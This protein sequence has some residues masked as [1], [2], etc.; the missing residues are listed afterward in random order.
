MSET[1]VTLYGG[2]VT[3]T[4]DD[5]AHTYLWE[6][7]G[8]FLPGPTTAIGTLPKP[9]LAPWAAKEMYLELC[10]E[11]EKYREKDE[12]G[13]DFYRVPVAEAEPMLNAAK[14]A[15]KKKKDTAANIGTL[16]HQY[17]KDFMTTGKAELPTDPYAIKGCEGFRT[18]LHG[19]E[20]ATIF[21][22]RIVV[23]R[24]HFY[25]GTNDLYAVIEN[26]PTVADFKT[27]S[28]FSVPDMP[29]QL[30]AYAIAIEEEFGELIEHGLIIRLDK[31][32]GKFETREFELTDQVKDGFL[33]LLKSYRAIKATEEFYN[34]IRKAPQDRHWLSQ[35]ERERQPQRSGVEG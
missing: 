21:S 1:T 33:Q 2:D 11:I 12:F 29:Y 8:L 20:I 15:H 18:W 6:E 17:A 5:E 4:F 34:G 19:R 10:R 7:K 3:V 22:E 23:S 24:R 13:M 14:F 26:K 9:W 30:A 31:E 16:V 27:S 28:Q 35:K 32:S 25:A